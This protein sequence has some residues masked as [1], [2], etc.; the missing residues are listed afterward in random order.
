MVQSQTWRLGVG[1]RS[2]A[3]LAAVLVVALIAAGGIWLRAGVQHSVP[4]ARPASTAS[5]SAALKAYRSLVD[6][7]FQRVSTAGRNTA[8]SCTGHAYSRCAEDLVTARTALQAFAQDLS[9]TSAP[10]GLETANGQL[11]AGIQTLTATASNEIAAAQAGDG[12]QVDSLGFQYASQHGAINLAVAGI[13]CW[14]AGVIDS[15]TNG[16]DI[17]YTCVK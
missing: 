17:K 13:D 15:S 1:G 4:A 7:D 3:A 12:A 14:P 6:A 2:L 10:P 8:N 11:M 9:A 5:A 16:S